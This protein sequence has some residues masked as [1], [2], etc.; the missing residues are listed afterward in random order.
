[1]NGMTIGFVASL[2]SIA[3]VFAKLIIDYTR[4]KDRVE[5]NEERDKEERDKNAAKFQELYDSR[6]S[7]REDIVKITAILESVADKLSSLER[8]IDE[9]KHDVR[10]MGGA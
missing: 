3:G 7:T 1:M 10:N 4:L 5:Q 2:L 8:K 9:L 6:N